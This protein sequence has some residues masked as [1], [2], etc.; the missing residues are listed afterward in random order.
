MEQQI[1]LSP[2]VFLE[3][4]NKNQIYIM[5]DDLI[6][7]S[8]GGNKVRKALLYFQEIDAGDYNAVVTY[9]SGG[10]NH[11]RIIANM[12]AARAL[13]CHIISTDRESNSINRQLIESFGAV[14][15]VCHVDNVAATIDLTMSLLRDLGSKPY[16]IAGGGH[17][18]IGTRAYD[19]AYNQ[20]AD[21]SKNNNFEFDY[22]FLASGTGT[23]HAGL[24]CGK[25]RYQKVNQKIVGISIARKNPRG[26]QVIA[27]SVLSYLGRPVGNDL[28]FDDRFICGGYGRYDNTVERTIRRLMIEKGLPL[29]P[30]Y[31]GKAYAG[32][33]QYLIDQKIQNKNILFIHTGGTP[34]FCDWVG[35]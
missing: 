10:S 35:R 6:P 7:F 4:N 28:I 19:L 9:G 24:I 29:D 21:F 20:I 5:R 11:C 23:T 18:N 2:I 26:A 27:E 32:M 17:G 1:P 8:F 3:Q 15:H 25:K 31:T 14:I 16:F 34:L 13:N 30:C 22:I 33:E 12:A